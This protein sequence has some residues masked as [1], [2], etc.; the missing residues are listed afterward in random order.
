[1]AIIHTTQLP[2]LFIS[3]LGFRLLHLSGIH[4]KYPIVRTIALISCTTFELRSFMFK[5]LFIA[6]ATRSRSTFGRNMVEYYMVRGP[7]PRAEM[8][9]KSQKFEPLFG[10]RREHL[11]LLREFL[12]LFHSFRPSVQILFKTGFKRPI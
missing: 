1:M 5:L 10:P 8:I 6:N 4:L 9:E 7:K 2:L 12:R 11:F 3:A